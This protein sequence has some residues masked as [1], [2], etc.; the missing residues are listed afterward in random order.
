[1]IC[2]KESTVNVGI[3]YAYSNPAVSC[4]ILVHRSALS[5]G[6]ASIGQQPASILIFITQKYLQYFNFTRPLLNM[7]TD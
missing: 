3:I 5:S 4:I 2:K 7:C 1:M 6:S